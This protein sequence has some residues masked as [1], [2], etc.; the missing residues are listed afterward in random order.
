MFDWHNNWRKLPPSSM[1]PIMNFPKP[2]NKTI[3]IG[4][5][6]TTVNDK[7]TNSNKKIW[8]FVPKCRPSAKTQKNNM[9]KLGNKT[10]TWRSGW[11]VLRKGPRS[12][13]NSVLSG[14]KDLSKHQKNAARCRASATGWAGL[15]WSKAIKKTN[16][17]ADKCRISKH[18]SR[19]YKRRTANSSKWW[20]DNSARERQWS[21]SSS[22]RRRFST[23]SWAG[24]D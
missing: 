20:T 4:R 12:K 17:I 8:K 9:N 18:R 15:T 7:S 3:I 16:K 24:I 5:L 13:L 21:K 19:C 22:N 10:I 11:P 23:N 2:T 6:S 1:P 14:W